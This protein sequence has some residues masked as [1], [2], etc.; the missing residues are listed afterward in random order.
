VLERALLESR[1]QLV[2]FVARAE[3]LSTNNASVRLRRAR[4]ALKKNLEQTRGACAQHGC[5]DCSCRGAGGLTY[6]A[7]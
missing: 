1:R 3:K 6:T 2:A 7:K 4:R 5:L